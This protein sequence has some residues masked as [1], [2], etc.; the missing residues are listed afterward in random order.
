MEITNMKITDGLIN[1]VK[2]KLLVLSLN[3]PDGEYAVCG[4]ALL[5]FHQ[6]R[7]NLNDI[8]ILVTNDL[9]QN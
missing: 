1:P 5:A 4:G 3:L 2:A 9:L 7:D 6:I 8:D